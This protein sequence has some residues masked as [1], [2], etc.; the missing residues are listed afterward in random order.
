FRFVRPNV[1]QDVGFLHKDDWFWQYNKWP[2]PAGKKR[3]KCWVGLVVDAGR[4]GLGLV[5][6]SHTGTFDFDAEQVGNKLAFNPRFNPDDLDIVRFPGPAGQ[7][8]FFNYHTLHVGSVNKGNLT[9]VSME[10]TILF[11]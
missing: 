2:V 7:P 6:E 4:N 1:A 10:F 8:V 11:D 9:R 3:A 5:P